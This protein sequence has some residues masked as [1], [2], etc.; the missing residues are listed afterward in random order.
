MQL[1]FH[2]TGRQFFFIT[3]TLEGRVKALSCLVEDQKRPELTPAG[4]IMKA[5]LL[6]MHKVFPAV[7][8]SDNVIMPDHVHFLLI[9]NYEI[10]PKFNPLWASHMLMDAVEKGW[11]LMAE[12]T[13]DSP[14]P[15]DMPTLLAAAVE[16]GRVEAAMIESLM[17]EGLTRGEAI[18]QLGAGE[19]GRQPQ[20][21]R[22]QHLRFDRRCY[23]ELSFDSRQLKAIRRYIRLNQVRALW[24]QQHPDRF[25]CHPSIRQ[26]ILDAGRRW[27]AMGAIT[28]LGSPFLFHVRLTLKKSVAEHEEA[29]KEIV[30]KAKR[31]WIP[32]SG[33]ISPGE[34]EALRRLKATPGTRFIKMMPCALPDRYDPS[35]EDSRELAADRM[36]I[37][38]GFP[39]T[40][41][42]SGL[43]IRKAIGASHQFRANCLAMNELIADLCKRAMEIN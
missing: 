34:V 8:I 41:A 32:V 6:A 40:P 9:V 4:E 30:E 3:L 25:V 11:G 10:A 35:A 7:T 43:D 27:Q 33:F 15:P 42:I 21:V 24:K 17:H 22:H 36:L 14:E 13:G 28:L 5:G 37:L 38:S 2:H 18:E 31:G 20:S 16:K 26:V 23:I 19:R 1:H 12:C 29:I 39:D